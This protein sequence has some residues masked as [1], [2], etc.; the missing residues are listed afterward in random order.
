M[1]QGDGWVIVIV[2]LA[3]IIACCGLVWMREGYCEVR[4]R[5]ALQKELL[6]RGLAEWTRNG[7]RIKPQR[8]ERTK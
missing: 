2:G 7:F 1:F 6:E 8:E 5:H 3:I 4:G